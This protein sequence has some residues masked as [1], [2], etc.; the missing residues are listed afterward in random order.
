MQSVQSVKSGRRGGP[1]AVALSLSLSLSL[2][3][4]LDVVLER[5]TERCVAYDGGCEA[6]LEGNTPVEAVVGV[7]IWGLKVI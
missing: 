1:Y 4:C 3:R 6:L 7:T 2:S 5:E